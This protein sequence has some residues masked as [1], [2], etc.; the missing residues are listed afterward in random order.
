[1]TYLGMEFKNHEELM[2]W[3]KQGKVASYKKLAHMFNNNPSMEISSMMSDLADVLMSRF[4]MTLD[5]L[6]AIEIEAMA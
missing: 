5:E 3:T 4:G 6:E 1:M 2:Q